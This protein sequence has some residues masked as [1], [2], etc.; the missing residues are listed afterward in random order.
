MSKDG[1]RDQPLVIGALALDILFPPSNRAYIQFGGVCA[2]IACALGNLEVTPLFLSAA[3]ESALGPNCL[4]AYFKGNNVAWRTL[5]RGRELPVFLAWLDEFGHALRGEFVDKRYLRAVS[6]PDSLTSTGLLKRK[7]SRSSPAQIC[8]WRPLISYAALRPPTKE[9]SGLL[10]LT[11]M[12][13]IRC[14]V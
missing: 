1:C 6:A 2:N 10:L 12:R 13:S 11:T 9:H 5:S 14:D 8:P 3:H 4:R 7:H